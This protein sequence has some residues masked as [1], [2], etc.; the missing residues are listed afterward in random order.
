MVSVAQTIE[1]GALF[2]TSA[3]ELVIPLPGQLMMAGKVSLTIALIKN[4]KQT[5]NDD[6]TKTGASCR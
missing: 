2:C 5:G 4:R 3:P 6:P 1:K